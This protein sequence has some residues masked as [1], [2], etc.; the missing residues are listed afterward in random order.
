M[1]QM[2]TQ[3]IYDIILKS[4]RHKLFEIYSAIVDG[5]FAQVE[6]H[7]NQCIQLALHQ[8]AHLPPVA[9]ADRSHH[10]LLRLQGVWRVGPTRLIPLPGPALQIGAPNPLW[11]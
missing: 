6:H 5:K 1:K 11:S 4:P 3:I 9:T 7:C 10:G 2:R 8:W